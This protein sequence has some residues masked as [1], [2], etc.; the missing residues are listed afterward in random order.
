M[1][2]ALRTLRVPMVRGRDTDVDV[3]RC[4]VLISVLVGNDTPP[5]GLSR[6]RKGKFSH[7]SPS[8]G[9]CK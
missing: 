6:T 8:R 5:A 4:C 7:A 1:R 9:K 2:D 3:A